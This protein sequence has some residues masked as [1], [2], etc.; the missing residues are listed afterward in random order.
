MNNMKMIRVLKRL[1]QAEVA[2]AMGIDRR[3]Y[4]KI[5]AGL[6]KPYPAWVARIE[7]Y[8][9]VEI[10]FLLQEV[11]IPKKVKEVIKNGKK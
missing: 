8:F 5:E 7:T 11:E 4:A 3:D 2:K 1:T 10:D 9:G 6:K